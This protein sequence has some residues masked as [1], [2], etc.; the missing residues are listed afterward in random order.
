MGKIRTRL[1][2]D[3]N[4]EKKQKKEAQERSERK[5]EQLK[6]ATKEVEVKNEPA[7]KEIEPAP[8][9]KTDKKPEVK[10]GAK[11]VKK[12][13][14]KYLE[15]VKKVDLRKA[16]ALLEA[17]E[18]LKEIAYAGF[19]ESVELHINTIETGL[20]GEAALPHGTGKTIR[21]KIVDEAVIAQIEKGNLDFDVLISHP[22]FMS[23]L[24]RFARILGPKGLMPNPKSGTIGLEPEKI[25]QKFQKGN[26]RWKT[27]PKFPIIH[28]VIGKIS[29]KSDAIC[30][31]AKNFIESVGIDKMTKAYIKTTMSPALNIDIQKL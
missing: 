25:A 12:H 8:P 19:D 24:A 4:I 11:K 16:Y 30:E 10:K 7:S 17:I 1:I 6:K 3:E 26:V 21:V 13:G 14:K 31:N 5:K 9:K 15:A 2:G 29:L 27:E 23:K 22:S 20:K 18:K 28:Q